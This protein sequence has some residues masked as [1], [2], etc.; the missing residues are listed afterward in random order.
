MP[1]LPLMLRPQA[2]TICEIAFGMGSSYR[3]AL[4]AGLNVEGV[5]LVPSVPGM[6]DYFY[7]D[8][9]QVMSNPNGHLVVADG[10]NHIELTTHMYDLAMA[11][12]PPPIHSSGAGVL[13]SQEFYKAVKAHL[14]PGG[15]MMEWMPYDQT[16]DEFRAHVQT[17]HSVFPN[18]ILVFGPTDSGVYMLGSEAP[19]EFTAEN[20]RSILSRPGVVADLASSPQAPIK[21]LDPQDWA[22]LVMAQI[23]IKG[24]QIQK[25]AGDAALITDDRPY[26]EYYLVRKVLNRVFGP[27]SPRMSHESL[28]AATPAG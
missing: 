14:N 13:Y 19:V 27:H 20:V 18:D 25:F 7:P 22:D 6:F 17:F 12:P 15:V 11:D 1:V 16:V 8:A 3:S 23:W 2:K 4:I 24:D 26:T 5:E 21:S 10:R 28:K 9:A